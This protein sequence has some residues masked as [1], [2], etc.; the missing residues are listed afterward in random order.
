MQIIK[1]PVLGLARLLAYAAV[2]VLPKKRTVVLRGFPAYEDNLIAIYL[3]LVS[4]KFRQIVWVIDDLS[5]RPPIRIEQNTKMVKRGGV[6]DIYYSITSRILFITHGHFLSK[7]PP[8]QV[9]VNLWHGIPLKKIGK[10]LGERGRSDTFLVATSEFTQ[11]IFAQSFDTPKE[12]ILITGQPRTDRM[13]S[14]NR[15]NVLSRALQGKSLPKLVLFWLP[16]FRRSTFSQ[17]RCDGEHFGNIFNCSD[18]SVNVFNT[19]LRKHDAICFVKPHP[20]AVK[21]NTS[22]ESNLFYINEDWMHERSLSLYELIG[23]TD[24]LISDISSVITDFMLLNRPIVLLF[25]DIA[26]YEENRGFSFNPITNYLPAEVNRNFENFITEIEEV[27]SGRDIYAERRE[28][29]RQ[30]FFS[31]SDTGAADRILNVAFKRGILTDKLLRTPYTN[32]DSSANRE[33][34]VASKKIK[35]ICV[36]DYYLP[37]FKGGGPIRTIANMRPILLDSVDI[38][39]FTRDRDLGATKPYSSIESDTWIETEDG[40]VYYASK[41]MFGYTGLKKAISTSRLEFEVLYLNSFFG[42]R[43]SIQMNFWFRREFPNIPILLAPRGEFSPGALSIKPIKKN[44]FITLARSLH[45]YQKISWHASTESERNDI[46]RLFHSSADRVHVAEDPVNIDFGLDQKIIYCPSPPGTLRLAFI[47]RISPM[48]NIDGLLRIVYKVSCQI[49]LSIFG[50]I[51]DLNYWQECQD[52]IAALPSNVTASYKNALQPET[53]SSVFSGYDLFA[54]PTHGENFGHVIFEALR[55]GTPVLVSE[56]TPWTTDSFGAV[57]VIPLSDTAAWVKQ[58]HSVAEMSKEEKMQLHLA[59][60]TYAESYERST[61]IAEKNLT[62]FKA[63]I[64]SAT[65]PFRNQLVG[66]TEA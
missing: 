15:N 32:E 66:I 41:P 13:L 12:N 19:I 16:T 1:K 39:I 50:P 3:A 26:T 61:G 24:C 36:I 11:N 27:L 25:E 6:L 59:A 2:R 64:D 55:A 49:D 40:P 9:C 23:A 5:S 29:L 37:G 31:H 18:F 22:D 21:Q 8:N 54:F 51:E 17:D 10:L 53:V 34:K 28:K 42:L 20:M 30:L 45:L 65:R 38:A 47:S 14:V 7:I 57:T 58:L 33:E 56:R 63:V 46:I 60:R 62:M 44:L 48:K 52:L 43:S 35:V 4:S